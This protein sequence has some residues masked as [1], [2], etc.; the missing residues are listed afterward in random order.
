MEYHGIKASVS[1]LRRRL[2]EETRDAKRY[3]QPYVQKIILSKNNK[4]REE[5][6]QNHQAKSVE[7][8]WKYVTDEAHIDPPSCTQ[9]SI[10]REEG[11]GLDPEN[12]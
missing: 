9:G 7:D 11:H 6:G 12:I 1:Q 10:L 3:K 5:Y 2:K 8:F 4:K